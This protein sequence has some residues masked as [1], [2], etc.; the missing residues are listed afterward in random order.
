MVE[1]LLEPIGKFIR[2]PIMAMLMMGFIIY[3]YYHHHHHHSENAD[4]AVFEILQTVDTN[5]C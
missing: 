1:K 2:I 5:M 4:I 3:D